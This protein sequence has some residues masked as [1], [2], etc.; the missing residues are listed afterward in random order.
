MQFLASGTQ[1]VPPDDRRRLRRLLG[2]LHRALPALR[3]ASEDALSAASPSARRWR[4]PARRP[5]ATTDSSEWKYP[6]TTGETLYAWMPWVILILCCAL[7]G[8]PEFKKL[9]NNLLRGVT[10][11]RRCSARRSRHA[12]A[13]GVGHAVAA[14][15]GAA[16]AAG[17]AASMP[18]RRPRGSRSTGCRPPEPACSSRRSCRDSCSGSTAAQWKRSVRADDAPDEDSGAGDRPGA[19]ASAS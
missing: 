9:L 8:M 12:V 2:H 6:Y 18:S 19:R 7:W 15:P 11:A 3:L 10:F 17:R 1:R 16:H 5:A 13:A 14:Q 4:R